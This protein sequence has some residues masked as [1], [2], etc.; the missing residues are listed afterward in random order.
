[1]YFDFFREDSN[2]FKQDPES[3][4]NDNYSNVK[5]FPLGVEADDDGSSSIDG[6]SSV[7]GSSSDTSG[8]ESEPEDFEKEPLIGDIE[9]NLIALRRFIDLTAQ[10]CYRWPSQVLIEAEYSGDLGDHHPVKF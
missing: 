2:G 1:M 8:L 10:V 9:N 3:K 4:A 7:E 6:S 5:I